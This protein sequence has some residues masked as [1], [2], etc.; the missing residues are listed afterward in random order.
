[1]SDGR[2]NSCGE[3]IL[4]PGLSLKDYIFFLFWEE[5]TETVTFIWMNLFLTP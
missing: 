3:I 2:D 4:I 1:M 5:I